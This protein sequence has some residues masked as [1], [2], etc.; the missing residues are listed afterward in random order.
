MADGDGG[1]RQNAS[2]ALL[3]HDRDDGVDQ[4]DGA[5][6]GQIDGGLP[7]F[8]LEIRELPRRRSTRVYEERIDPAEMLDGHG[9]QAGRASGSATSAVMGSTWLPV[10]RSRRRRPR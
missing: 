4:P 3:A 2:P 8:D 9:G 1:V 5:G 6:D 10:S 7:V